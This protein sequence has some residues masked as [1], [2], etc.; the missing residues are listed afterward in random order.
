MMSRSRRPN[1]AIDRLCLDYGSC[2]NSEHLPTRH[3]NTLPKFALELS[4]V[5]DNKN[6]DG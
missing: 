4:R 1:R 3:L 2:K 6:D 5:P